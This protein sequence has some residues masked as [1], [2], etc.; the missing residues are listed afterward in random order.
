MF[1]IAT[2]IGLSMFTIFP[3]FVYKLVK[4]QIPDSSEIFVEAVEI[5]E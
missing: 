2:I 4:L 3:Y 1:I 5:T